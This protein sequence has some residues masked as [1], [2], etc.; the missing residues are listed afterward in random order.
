MKSNV[1]RRAIALMLSLITVISIMSIPLS[2]SAR[3]TDEDIENKISY[4][5]LNCREDD[6]DCLEPEN[7]KFAVVSPVGGNNTYNDYILVDTYQNVQKY[8][9][10]QGWTDGL[11][12]VPPTWIKAEK[13]M[14]YTSYNDN[15][16][17]ATVNG[18]SV[19][20]YQVAVNAIMSGCSAEYLPVCIAFVEALGNEAYLESLRS[21]ELTPMMYVNGPITRQLGIDNGQGMTT[22]ECNIAIARF[23]ELAL[24][25]LAGLERTNAFGNVQP[26]VFSEDEQNCIN[27]GWD[28]RHVEEGY[29]LN[30][31]VITATSFSMWGNNVTPATDLPQEIMKVMAWDITEKNLGGLG[32]K[33]VEDN[34]NTHRLIFITPSVASALA[35]KYKSKDAL[36]SALVENARRPLWMRTYAYYYAN[37]G[38]ALSKSF[39]DVYDEL[40]AQESEDAKKTASPAWMNGIT[41]AEID[42]VATMKE[43]NTDIIIHGDESRNKTQVMPGGVSVS[44]EI[45]LP[46]T[47]D[48]LLASMIVSIVYQPLSACEISPVDLSVSLPSGN[49]IP[50][51][52]QV[53]KQTTYRIAASANYAN[54]TGKIYYNSST[55]TL[56]YWDGS[57]TQSVVLDKDVYAD[58]ITLVEALGV[59]SS[60]TLNRSNVVTAVY[61]RFSSN[62]SLPDKNMVDLTD[63]TF[64]TVVPTIAANA[65]S[66]SNGNASLDGAVITMSDT[67]TKF[68]AD[69]GGDIVMGDSTD[70]EFVTVSGTTVTI[71][72]SVESG[73]TAV[74][75]T[76]DG[77]GSYRT[78]TFVNGGDGTYTITYNS[79]NTLTLTAS[80]YY[81]KGTFN[82]WG[83]TDA[84]AKT[85][86]DDVVS[87]I[88]EI[89]A[90][91]Y[92]FKVHDAGKDVWHG[93]A[94]TINDTANRWTMDS[95]SDCT[96]NATGGTYEFKYEIS[97]NKLSVYYAQTDAA[98]TPTTKTVYV[99]VVEHIK[100]FV[101]TLHYWNNST[102]LTG[103][104]TLVATG[105]TQQYAV[106]SAYWNNAEQNFKIY[107]A[108]IP[109]AANGMKTYNKS[110]NS[111]W[112]SEEVNPTD[113]QIILV[114][115]YSNTYHNIL[116]TRIVEEPE[117]PTEVPTEAPTEEP[118][119]APTDAP[120]EAPT[121]E[122]TQAPTEAPAP[123]TIKVYFQNNWKWTNVHAYVWNDDGA[124]VTW[125]GTALTPVGNDGTYDIYCVEIPVG[126]KV[127]FNGTK[128]DGSGATDQTPNIEDA[129]N[130]RCYYMEWKDGNQVGYEDISKIWPDWVPDDPTDPTDTTEPTDPTDP[131]DPAEKIEISFLINSDTKW[132]SSDD[133]KMFIKSGSDV[134]EM[135]ETVDTESG[136]VMWTAE[137][138]AHSSYTFYR[139]SYFFDEDNATTKAWNTWTA[140]SRGTNTVFKATSSTGGSWAAASTVNAADPKDIE[141]FWDDLWIA[142]VDKNDVDHAVKVY[143][144]GSEFNLFVPSYYDLSN[145][146]VYSDHENVVIGSTTIASGSTASL[147]TG[148]DKTFQFKDGSTTTNKGKINIYQTTGVAAMMM[149]TKEELYTGT[150]AGLASDNA[151]PSGAGITSDNYNAVY[152]DA[153]ETKGSYHFYTED[154]TWLNAPVMDDGVE[155]DM[156]VLKKI[157]G[158]GNSSFEAS[159]RIY[160]KYAYNFNLD[161]KIEL[162]DGSTAS[163]K[164]CML[165]NN[166]D[167]SMLRNTFIYQLADDMG[168][169]M[170]PETRLVDVYDN[171]KYLGAFVIT[172]KVEYGKN[173]LMAKDS[174]GEKIN[175]LD[176]ANVDANSV[177]TADGEDYLYEF[178][179]DDLNAGIETSIPIGGKTYKYKYYATYD[180][181]AYKDEN[182]VEQPA[183]DNLTFETP[184]NYNTKYNYLLEHELSSRYTAEASWFITPKGQPV[185]VKY[186]EFATKAEMEWIINEYAAMEQAVYASGEEDLDEIGQLI[187]VESFAKM[188]LIHELAINLDSCA[189]SYYIHNEYING[190]SVLFAGPTWD[191]DWALGAYAGNTKWI[192]NG[193]SVTTSA[194]M[195]DPKQMF[196]KNKAIQTDGSPSNNVTWE[197]NYNLQAKLAHNDE[198]WTECQRIYTNEMVDLLYKYTKDSYDDAND[199]GVIVDEWLPKFESSMDMNNA[200]WGVYTKNDDWGTKVTT[201]YV[202]GSGLTSTS[203]FNIGNTGTSGSASKCYANTVYYLNDWIKVRKD[204]MSGT[205]DLYNADLLETYEISDVDFEGVLNDENGELTVTPSATVTLNG[206][207]VATANYFYTIYVNDEAVTDAIAF[208]TAS[209]TVDLPSGQES[210]VYIVVTVADSDVTEKSNTQTFSYGVVVPDASVTVYFKSS[211]SYRYVPT[212]VVGDKEITMTRDGNHI[213]ANATQTQKYYWYKAEVSAT[214]GSELSLMFTNKYNMR[215][216]TTVTVEEGK[217]YYFGCNNLN[218]GT[219]AVDITSLDE[220]IRN[221]VKSATNMLVNDPKAAGVATT[222]LDGTI[223]KM[224]DVDGDDSLTILDA[225]I[226]QKKLADLTELNEISTDLADY[227]VDGLVTVL[228]ATAIQ[229]YLANNG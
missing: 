102:G 53:S 62:A 172:E 170:G 221:F 72:P 5:E 195:S 114:F 9:D 168:M 8:F 164:W 84:F 7:N 41:Y 107:K 156:T 118:T 26:L 178:D 141:N 51:A 165:A 132:I 125:P 110:A 223:Y 173:T 52:L 117:D 95:S 194:N 2:A 158:R 60:F 139:T 137:V 151:W 126:Y 57:A 163:K 66:G 96:F 56:Y 78:M 3:Y 184:E 16:V 216:S 208:T 175:N 48:D 162:I 120:T 21:G 179:T 59:N 193:S 143:Y 191:F 14:R 37:T 206:E 176:D 80:S 71:D 182:G 154:G 76:S 68:T 185:V 214:E 46:S 98:A 100:D 201:D 67:V 169:T 91:T 171:G 39:S 32:Y 111:A 113:S 6:C 136:H 226:I 119:D 146:V 90:G 23:M 129:V 99:G 10:E 18:R 177:F 108:E 47:W 138:A 155:V 213:A 207:A 205:G 222:S 31:N 55:S 123:E 82:D 19:T 122:P 183:A 85:G 38:S 209:T 188:Y 103:D 35:K 198:F 190:K 130:N 64:G 106:G 93:N 74:I 150:T 157:K 50:T 54:G 30:D 58:F 116:E 27:I 33:S 189:T 219:T 42:T 228:D 112:A 229:I 200:R 153:I 44:Q 75:G 124:L 121:E 105:E 212:L 77:S 210:E 144:D 88:K 202:K 218:N 211:S 40:K 65:T 63:T 1:L 152:K 45:S 167:H 73:A 149:T 199:T 86:N 115:E 83:V 89:P 135:D 142:P 28:P 81:L 36:E 134:I 180:R 92:T 20:A 43:G 4:H 161:E 166:V 145:V 11:P 29:D 109:V 181:P 197:A 204:Y 187:D 101:P 22:E 224:G 34:A 13:F 15:D 133:A 186:P 220:N 140:S 127:I 24:I 17:V 203:G 160:G 94:G 159:M 174:V 61:A 12:I 131:D 227:D 128:D 225:T 147:T 148:L 217:A 25:N 97:T 49:G 192:Y 79:A 87:I 104:A 70:A 69:L 215:A 196:A